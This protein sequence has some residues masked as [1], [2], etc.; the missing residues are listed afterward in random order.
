[1]RTALFPGTFSPPTLGHL[2]IIHRATK[3]C[4]KLVIAVV[5]NPSKA[6]STITAAEKKA[7]LEKICFPFKNVEIILFTGLLIDLV[8]KYNINFIIRGLRTTGDFEYEEQMAVANHVMSGIETVFLL[9]S[10]KYSHI[11]STLVREIGSLGH[12][13]HGFIPAEIEEDVCSKLNTK[14]RT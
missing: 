5:E 4:D 11:S 8:P 14:T 6:S 12:R 9:T 1:M 2:D 10:P 3:L 7:Y 13:L